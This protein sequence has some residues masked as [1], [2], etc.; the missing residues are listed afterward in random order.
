MELTGIGRAKTLVK[1]ANKMGLKKLG[2]GAVNVTPSQFVLETTG[3]MANSYEFVK[4]LGQGIYMP[5]NKMFIG[6]YGIVYEAVHKTT[7]ERRAIKLITKSVVPHDQEEQL[8]SEI[9][10][11]KQMASHIFKFCRIIQG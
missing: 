2:T 7:K 1:K 3:I 6:A 11:L 9:K 8:F 10:V 4:Q 5:I